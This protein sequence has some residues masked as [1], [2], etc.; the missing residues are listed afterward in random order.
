MDDL[1]TFLFLIT[2]SKL[3]QT[4]IAMLN[5]F[6]FHTFIAYFLSTSPPIKIITGTIGHLF[7][8]SSRMPIMN[9]MKT[10]LAFAVIAASTP[11]MATEST[12]PTSFNV[13]A[14][15]VKANISTTAVATKEAVVTKAIEIK[16]SAVAQTVQAKDA[17]VIKAT[18]VKDAVATKTADVKD[19]VV[20]QVIAAKDATVTETVEAKDAVTTKATEVKDAIATKTTDVKDAVVQKEEKVIEK[21]EER[22]GVIAWFKN[23]FA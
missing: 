9:T 5:K 6:K 3:Q 1:K 14:E 15:Q 19:A 8:D 2:V 16:D 22:K 7:Y 12:T 13:Q 4:V 20:T 11:A 21:T 23:L 10:V 18:E 17:T